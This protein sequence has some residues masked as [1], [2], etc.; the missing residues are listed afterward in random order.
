MTEQLSESRQGWLCR[1]VCEI[2]CLEIHPTLCFSQKRD[3]PSAK[4]R[5]LEASLLF[6]TPAVAP[7]PVPVEAAHSTLPSAQERWQEASAEVVAKLDRDSG[8]HPAHEQK[9]LHFPEG[10][11][12]KNVKPAQ[13]TNEDGIKFVKAR[14]CGCAKNCL[15][16]WLVDDIQEWRKEVMEKHKTEAAR[17]LF[18][19]DLLARYCPTR[20]SGYHAYQLPKTPT[21]VDSQLFHL[22][23]AAF[24]DILGVSSGKLT[25]SI[26]LDQFRAESDLHGN[27]AA[28]EAKEVLQCASW[29]TLYDREFCEIVDDKTHHTPTSEPDEERYEEFK[30]DQEALGWDVPSLSLFLRVK[31]E[32]FSQCG[33]TNGHESR[34]QCQQTVFTITSRRF[35]FEREFLFCFASENVKC[36]CEND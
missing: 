3:L 14:G 24:L 20:K 23:R 29:W 31:R 35:Q 16:A 10:E 1:A 22:C 7:E 15:A 11:R 34:L 30:A 18:I 19:V 33:S 9:R 13:T 6:P 32:Q 27:T 12:H 21:A 4:E 2:V 17:N 8:P 36:C 5:F 28:R 26:H 25:H